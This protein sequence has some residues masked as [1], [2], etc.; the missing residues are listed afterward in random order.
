MGIDSSNPIIVLLSLYGRLFCLL[1]TSFF[2]FR[3]HLRPNLDGHHLIRLPSTVLHWS[4]KK[5]RTRFYFT[6]LGLCSMYRKMICSYDYP[7]PPKYHIN[8]FLAHPP[9][10]QLSYQFFNRLFGNSLSPLLK[11]LKKKKCLAISSCKI[12]R[13]KKE[14]VY[15][16]SI[17]SV[18]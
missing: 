10:T 14:Y 3:W 11:K 12:P 16:I 7:P 13:K 17:Y 2:S 15:C 18:V 4:K 1:F 9:S 6:F 8:S 5:E